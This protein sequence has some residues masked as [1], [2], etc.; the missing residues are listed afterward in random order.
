M[1]S[2]NRTHQLFV[3]PA[4]DILGFEVIRLLPAK[5]GG[6]SALLVR[7]RTSCSGVAH[8]TLHVAPYDQRNGIVPREQK[9]AS[10]FG[11]I[12]EISPNFDDT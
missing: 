12:R 10:M 11:T 8:K 4:R 7:C 6:G 5:G 1:L 2:R 3:L 9:L